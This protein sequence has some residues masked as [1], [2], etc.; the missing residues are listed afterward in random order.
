[1]ASAEV[2]TVL[3]VQCGDKVIAHTVSDGILAEQY[4][5]GV[6]ANV[7]KCLPHMASSET[8]CE[9]CLRGHI[10]EISPLR[11]SS[12]ETETGMSTKHVVRVTVKEEYELRDGY[13]WVDPAQIQKMSS[14]MQ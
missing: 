8:V 3:I 6:I 13:F 11:V 9:D 4:I 14:T 2:F 7:S 10:K 12:I 5:Y 1:M